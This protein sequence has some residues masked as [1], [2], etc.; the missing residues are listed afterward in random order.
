MTLRASCHCRATQFDV[1]APPESLTRCT[2]SICHKRGVLWAY[3][4]PQDFTLVT[5]RDRVSTYQFGHYVVC[6]HHCAN[7]GCSTFSENPSWE[8]G[9]ADFSRMTI[10]I[11]ARLLDDFDLETVPVNIV[12]GKNE[13]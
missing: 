7:C 1:A 5:A 10:A 13:W 4:Q 9:V 11:N 12:D 6:H 3:Y 2:C 8:N